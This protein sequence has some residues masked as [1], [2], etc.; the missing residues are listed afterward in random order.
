MPIQNPD[1]FAG[2]PWYMNPSVVGVATNI[3]IAFATVVNVWVSSRMGK[4]NR[5]SAEA[6]EQS[7]KIAN[8]AVALTRSVFEASN[9][10]YMDVI[11]EATAGDTQSFSLSFEIT[12]YGNV[13]LSIIEVNISS[14]GHAQ[15]ITSEAIGQSVPPGGKSWLSC[16]ITS[17]GLSTHLT[18]EA[19]P[20]HLAVK[21]EYQS[22]ATNLRYRLAKEYEYSEQ[23]T[24]REVHPISLGT[25]GVGTGEAAM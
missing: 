24:L 22:L 7:A 21:F 23:Q 15:R 4:A 20:I 14:G 10:P 16:P 9:R 19:Q 3:V 8:D 13:P 1:P 5:R 12:N 18:S 25:H 11:N 2:L 17:K 6:A